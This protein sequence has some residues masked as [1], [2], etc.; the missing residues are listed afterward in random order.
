M[1]REDLRRQGGEFPCP[2]FPLGR[3]FYPSGGAK[4]WSTVPT[5]AQLFA[6][7]VSVPSPSPFAPKPR[8]ARQVAK[9]SPARGEGDRV[10]SLPAVSAFMV[11][12][13]VSA[14]SPSPLVGEGFSSW[15]AK[16]GLEEKGEGYGHDTSVA[17]STT[18]RVVLLPRRSTTGEDPSRGLGAG[19]PSPFAP[20]PRFARQVA[21]PSPARGEGYAP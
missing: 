20:K 7:R 16:P 4:R 15:P 2:D 8:F 5:A 17:P 18:L 12:A 3:R 19:D 9:P 10:S 13:S 6:G 1:R 14:R 21:K 11:L